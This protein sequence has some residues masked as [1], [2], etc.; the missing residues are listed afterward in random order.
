MKNVTPINIAVTN[1][2]FSRHVVSILAL[3]R[4]DKVEL[5]HERMRGWSNGTHN[6]SHRTFKN[7][8]KIMIYLP[9][10]ILSK[11]IYL[12]GI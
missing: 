8:E 4:R 10:L 1:V 3:E 11:K 7:V 5:V 6:G 12:G 9:Y 2:F